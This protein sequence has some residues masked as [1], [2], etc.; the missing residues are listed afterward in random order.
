MP[1]LCRQFAC[2]PLASTN[3]WYELCAA[4]KCHYASVRVEIGWRGGR[5]RCLFCERRH[6]RK[7]AAM[8]AV[9]SA[10]LTICDN[11]STGWLGPVP[12]A[13]RRA[14]PVIQPD[15]DIGDRRMTGLERC[16]P[17]ALL[18]LAARQAQRQHAL[19][20]LCTI[21]VCH[22]FSRSLRVSAHTEN[23][24]LPVRAQSTPP[25]A[26]PHNTTS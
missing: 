8:A 16:Q 7:Q 6:A 11:I 9:K 24:Q 26:A 4:R 1:A 22:I 12:A 17:L 23:R 18:G 13:K 3:G 5:S 14:S 2:A 20:C 15:C 19:P 21:V 10:T 25:G